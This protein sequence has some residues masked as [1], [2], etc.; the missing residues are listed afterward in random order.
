MTSAWVRGA[1]ERL[2]TWILEHV[3]YVV[4]RGFSTTLGVFIRLYCAIDPGYRSICWQC[5][6]DR[7]RVPSVRV[8]ALFGGNSVNQD[9]HLM[10]DAF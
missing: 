7:P 8:H 10:Q 3:Y 5:S 6:P 2:S 4:K 9:A 1:P